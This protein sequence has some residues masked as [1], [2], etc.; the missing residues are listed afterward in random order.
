MLMLTFVTPSAF[1]LAVSVVLSYLY[2]LLARMFPKAFIWAT[3][4]LK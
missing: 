3:G 1:I 4:I 2:V